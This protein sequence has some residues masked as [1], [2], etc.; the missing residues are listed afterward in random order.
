MFIRS[1]MAVALAAASVSAFAVPASGEGPNVTYGYTGHGVNLHSLSN[2]PAQGFYV[3]PESDRFRMGIA[4]S[5]GIGYEM[6][7][8]D[9][10]L[11]RLDDVLDNLERDDIGVAEGIALANELNDVLALIGRDGYARLNAGLQAP[12]T[13]IVVRTP[14]GTFSVSIEADA[15]VK[16]SVLDDAVVYS[17]GSQELMTRSSLYLKSATLARVSV[18]WS[19]ELWKK[20]RQS[21]V[22]G[23]RLNIINGALSKQVINLKAAAT[24]PDDDDVGDIISDQYDTNET[25]TTNVSIDL[26][27][28]YRIDDWRVGLTLKN[29]N[30]P[31]FDYGTVGAGC[32]SLAAG[33]QE[34]ANCMSADYFAQDGRISASETWVLAS[35]ATVDGAYIFGNGRGMVGFSYDLTDINLPT[36]DLQQMFSL[37]TAYQSPRM[38]LPG[39]RAGYHANRKGSELSSISLGLTFFNG[40]T[41]DVLMGLEDTEI[42][43]DSLPR[44]AAVSLGWQSGF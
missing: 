2:N 22:G 44:T 14:A 4:G 41:L 39:V 8:V 38:W 13:P 1:F 42:D 25:K 28:I 10:F 26:G 35:Q 43:G 37:V 33:S 36:G 3:V 21:L 9:N 23:A 5:L 40:L 11:D 12:L 7:E 17:A 30:E 27:V 16:A 6:G 15:E 19:D 32:A 31:E 34:Y 18:G 24:S 29:I 20:E